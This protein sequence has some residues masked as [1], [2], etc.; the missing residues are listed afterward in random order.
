[1]QMKISYRPK[2][3]RACIFVVTRWPVWRIFCW[4]KNSIRT[5]SRCS[6]LLRVR[7]SWAEEANCGKMLNLRTG[8]T[9][10]M[11]RIQALEASH[12]RLRCHQGPRGIAKSDTKSPSKWKTGLAEANKRYQVKME[13]SEL[14]PACHCQCVFYFFCVYVCPGNASCSESNRLVV[15]M[16]FALH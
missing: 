2:P 3:S 4:Q 9:K 7:S 1:M 10:R 12:T 15:K 5:P 8:S 13:A 6:W 11:R 16:I 14:I